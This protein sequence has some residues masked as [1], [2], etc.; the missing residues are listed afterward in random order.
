MDQAKQTEFRRHV[1]LYAKGNYVSYTGDAISD[2]FTI[3]AKTGYI[4]NVLTATGEIMDELIAMAQFSVLQL[5]NET[6]GQ[7]ELS[8]SLSKEFY[9]LMDFLYKNRLEIVKEHGLTP[10]QAQG[11][12][13]MDMWKHQEHMLNLNLVQ[14][15]LVTVAKW[16]PEHGELGEPEESIL[17][18]RSPNKKKGGKKP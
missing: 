7:P 11:M 10:M 5:G 18:V 1:A 17:P 4:Q 12:E 14:G 3:G 16:R 2:L 15:L 8:S 6:H 9:R 13:V